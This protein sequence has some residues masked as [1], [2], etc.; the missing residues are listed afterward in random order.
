MSVRLKARAP[1]P[2]PPFPSFHVILD[3]TI[4]IIWHRAAYDVQSST[5]VILLE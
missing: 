4:T 3:T 1:G 5:N 2:T